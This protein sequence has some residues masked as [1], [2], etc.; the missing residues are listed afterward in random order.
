[1]SK[2]IA[3]KFLKHHDRYNS[4]EVAGFEDAIARLLVAQGIAKPFDPAEEAAELAA[5]RAEAEELDA[6]AA[7]LAAREAELDAREAALTSASTAGDPPKQ[8][9]TVLDGKK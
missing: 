6:R 8:G 5:K 4:G 7:A 1:M 2:L 9:V 3:L